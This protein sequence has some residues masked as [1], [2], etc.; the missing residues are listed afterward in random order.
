M[1]DRKSRL[2]WPS[3]RSSAAGPAILFALALGGLAGCGDDSGTPG[4]TRTEDC[5]AGSYCVDGRCR[6]ADGGGDADADADAPDGDAPEGEADAADDG[7]GGTHTGERCDDLHPCPAGWVCEEGACALDCG[8]A[9]RCGDAV[10]CPLDQVCYLGACT[11][12]GAECA[13]ELPGECGVGGRC[14]E[15]EQCDPSIDRCMPVPAGASCEF[16][17]EGTFDPTLLWAWDGATAHPT[18]RHAIVTPVV[19]D[20]DADGAADVIVPVTESIP[21][22]PTVGGI[23]CALSGLGDC[24]G[25]PRELWCT[26]PADPRVNWVG[27]PAVADLEGTGE[28]TIVVGDGRPGAGCARP[29]ELACGITAYDETGVRIPGFGTDASGRPV[30]VFVWVGGPG[31]ADLDGD[32]RAEIY[33]G[34]TVF[35]SD[36][37]LVWTHPASY[38]YGPLTVAVDLDGDGD[39]ELVGGNMAFH[40]DGTEAWAPGV[41]AR[42]L[43][44]GWPAVADFDLDGS[45]EVVVVSSGAVRVF[46]ADG[47][48]FS[49]T[50][51]VVAGLGGPPTIADL[52]GDGTP[53]IAVAGQN[54]LTTFRVGPA[55]DH[56]LTV[57]WQVPSRDFSSNFTGSSVF[58]FDG[59]GRTEVIYGDE[60]FA[61][62]YDG[63]GD[64]AG[65]TTVR[66]EVPNTSCTGTEYP[67]VADLTGDGKAEF[68]V[69]GNN[70]EAMASAC[71]PYVTQCRTA[72]PGYEPQSGVRVYRDR[73][74]NW[75]AT[76]AIWNQHTYHVTN[77]C[78]GRD[79][80]CPAGENRYAAVPRAEQPSWAFPA[81][82]PLNSFRVNAQLDGAFAAPNLV[83]RNARADLSLCPGALGL[84]VEVTNLG[85]LGVPFGVP[86]AFYHVDS[87]TTR[88]LIGVGRTRRVLLPGGSEPVRVDWSPL[89]AELVDATIQVEIVVDDDGTGHGVANECDETDNAATIAPLCAGLG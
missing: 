75:V 38:A 2:C 41:A 51:A 77:V 86:V 19:A 3:G 32:G 62:V 42:G 29:T 36:G 79:G 85:A 11:T 28:L 33:V 16:R 5:P 14:P 71:S 44:D 55:P 21:G 31:I 57:L 47:N 22:T 84:R 80:V 13:E 74:D 69:V 73:N 50:G 49:A 56:A 66:F 67:V 27:Q 43:D 25:G 70:A 72:Y 89:P 18:F 87:A 4:C 35:D 78:D 64:G 26:D 54:S 61:R 53:D 34:F 63:P 37:R 68:V 30:D 83:P 17:P 6:T 24:A 81:A 59:D 1:N 82:G 9:M 39:L 23:L 48:L 60:C 88:T 52:D 20:I 12:P 58:D 8:G 46:D 65:G 45:P 76:R 40:D 15:G 10:C 7:D